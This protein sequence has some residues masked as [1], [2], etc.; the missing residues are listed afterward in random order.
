M[1][2]YLAFIDSVSTI[3][4]QTLN[5]CDNLNTAAPLT[6]IFPGSAER[7]NRP[8]VNQ[9]KTVSETHATAQARLLM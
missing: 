8:A 9:N 6:I 7:P 2:S 1:H 4:P 5:R 3:F